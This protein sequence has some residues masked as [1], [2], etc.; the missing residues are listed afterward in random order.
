MRPADALLS[1]RRPLL[2]RRALATA[3]G[4]SE[5][6]QLQQLDYILD[7]YD[8]RAVT[9]DGR[10]WVTAGLEFWKEQFPWASES[11]IRRAWEN[12]AAQR[13]IEKKRGRESN[14]YTINYDV[15]D[16]LAL[17]VQIERSPRSDRTDDTAQIDR[18]PCM[19]SSEESPEEL[20]SADTADG[21]LFAADPPAPSPTQP[22]PKP[23]VD[24]KAEVEQK[25]EQV[26]AEYERVFAGHF[27]KGL[28][29]PR[30]TMIRKGLKAVENDAELCIRAV[31]G[32]WN[33]RRQNPGGNMAIDAIFRTYPGGSNLTD[34]I[35]RWA[36]N[37]EEDR[38]GTEN[39]H[40]HPEAIRAKVRRM[41]LQVVEMYQQPGVE[42]VKE[43]GE[44][45]LAWLKMQAK[46]EPVVGDGRVTGW[47]AVQ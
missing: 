47:R 42:G 30:R 26:W 15:L 13:L 32:L 46:E 4:L 27:T 40:V 43:R 22:D 3:V 35:S 25:V 16:K 7:H 19:K 17:S 45:A 44:N 23:G 24:A 10:R 6:I 39:L 18:A 38:G 33:Y 37:A 2:V 9:L 21:Q 28:T 8:S 14:V 11:T 5:A 1:E 41:R 36:E 34:Q 29:D 31:R 20:S 12:L